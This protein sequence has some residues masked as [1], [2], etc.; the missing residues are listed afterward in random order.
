NIDA[1]ARAALMAHDS[2]SFNRW[3]AGHELAGEILLSM[4][5]GTARN[6]PVP[7]DPVYLDAIASVL[8]RADEDHGFTAQMLTPPFEAELARLAALPDPDAIHLARKDLL[9]A[10]AERQGAG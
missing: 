8:E 1:K 9:R 3:E 5:E 4:A 7:V 6:E 10:I 2:D